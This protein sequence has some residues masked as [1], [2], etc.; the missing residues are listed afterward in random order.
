[1]AVRPTVDGK[2]KASGYLRLGGIGQERRCM[3]ERG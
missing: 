3:N 2:A 1:M